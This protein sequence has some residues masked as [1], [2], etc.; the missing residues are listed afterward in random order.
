MLTTNTTVRWADP[1]GSPLIGVVVAINGDS[2]R[3]ATP[4][5]V[6]LTV[7]IDKLTPMATARLNI[8]PDSIRWEPKNPAA[9]AL[10]ALRKNRRGGRPRSADP[11]CAC[12]A[13][14]AKR[15]AARAHK[16]PVTAA[17]STPSAPPPT[18][19]GR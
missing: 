2:A 17:P 13:M 9:V 11:R 6:T 3:V 12:G 7:A 18:P 5:G 14:T 19:A 16:C 15:A 8:Q 1:N 10:Q 4:Y